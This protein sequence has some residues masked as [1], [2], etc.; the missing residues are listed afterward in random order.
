MQQES[1]NVAASDY[2]SEPHAA[3][4]QSMSVPSSA[5]CAMQSHRS[6]HAAGYRTCACGTVCWS[7]PLERGRALLTAAGMR[8]ID[9]GA[10][11]AAQAAA[12][13]RQ[14]LIGAGTA[15]RTPG[16]R[17]DISCGWLLP[18]YQYGSVRSDRGC[19]LEYLEQT[20]DLF[21]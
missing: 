1:G 10:L 5:L 20:G 12:L 3:V 2:T 21:A 13:R 8:R 19:K 14:W 11:G 15:R 4:F 9:G 16:Q 18:C 6:S 17:E 7:R